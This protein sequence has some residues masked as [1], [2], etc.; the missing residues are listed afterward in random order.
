MGATLTGS[1][2][3]QIAEAPGELRPAERAVYDRFRAT[4][5]YASPSRIRRTFRRLGLN[6]DRL[7]IHDLARVLVHADPTGEVAVRRVLA[8]ERNV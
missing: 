4:G 7:D 6:R 5:E 3:D 1:G 8:G 2:P